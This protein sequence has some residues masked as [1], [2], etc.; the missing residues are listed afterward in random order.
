MSVLLAHEKQSA[1]KASASTDSS[2]DEPQPILVT[3]ATGAIAAAPA[4]SALAT[5]A[6]SAKSDY[7]NGPFNII[8]CF[9][10]IRLA[11]PIFP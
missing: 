8:S 6:I 1:P 3:S 10:F 4:T 5:D 7:G 9:I 2:D 11:F